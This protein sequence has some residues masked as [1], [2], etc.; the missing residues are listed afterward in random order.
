[1]SHF[2]GWKTAI[3]TIKMS[4]DTLVSIVTKY[5]RQHPDVYQKSYSYNDIKQADEMG[6][7]MVLDIVLGL[8]VGAEMV[9]ARGIYKLTRFFLSWKHANHML[10]SNEIGFNIHRCF[11]CVEKRLSG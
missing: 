10:V 7:Q 3:S 11:C 9:V 6:G 2:Y 8:T 4:G 1:V 5:Q